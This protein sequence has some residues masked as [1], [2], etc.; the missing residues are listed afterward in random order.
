MVIR[1]LKGKGMGIINLHKK[2]L[3]HEHKKTNVITVTL[4]TLAPFVATVTNWCNKYFLIYE[5]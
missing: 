3:G 5:I 2:T 1:S 4:L